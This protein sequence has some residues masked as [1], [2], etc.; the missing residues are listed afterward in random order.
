MPVDLFVALDALW[1]K[2]PMENL[3]PLY[4]LHRFLAS[5][6][7]LAIAA[8][9][10]QRDLRRGDP[11]ITF[12]VWQ[13][14]LPKERGAPRLSYVAPKKPPAVEQLTLRMM[15]VLK[16]SR[17]TVEA[18]QTTIIW[19]HREQELYAEFGVEPQGQASVETVSLG[20]GRKSSTGAAAH[21]GTSP[22]S[23]DPKPVTKKGRGK[24]KPVVRPSII[25]GGLLEE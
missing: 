3:P 13:G 14:L 11:D 24:K 25:P 23:P 7:D 19:A 12:R 10:L 15:E 2:A 18:M 4:I 22:T 9:E 21:D 8:R 1:T 5:E 6:P 16:E 20:S 17:T